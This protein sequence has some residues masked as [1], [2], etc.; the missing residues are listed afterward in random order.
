[1]EQVNSS[2]QAKGTTII[3]E[4]KLIS[5]KRKK[6]EK[7]YLTKVTIVEDLKTAK[8][9]INMRKTLWKKRKFI[10]IIKDISNIV[11]RINKSSAGSRRQQR[12][13]LVIFRSSKIW[14]PLMT[15]EKDHSLSLPFGQAIGKHHLNLNHKWA[16]VNLQVAYLNLQIKQVQLLLRITS[17]QLD[18][19]M[20]TAAMVEHP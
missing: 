14:E 18:L 7:D 19:H 3:A 5:M 1:L 11:A 6:V 8:K 20:K 13:L 9:L 4:S 15:L 10:I 17:I 12:R 16:K 2:F